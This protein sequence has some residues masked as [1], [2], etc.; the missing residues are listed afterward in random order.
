MHKVIGGTLIASLAMFAGVAT[1]QDASI[2]VEPVT[3]TMFQR[4]GEEIRVYSAKLICGNPGIIKRPVPFADGLGGGPALVPGEYL[5]AVNIHNPDPDNAVTFTKKVAEA[6]PERLLPEVGEVSDRVTETLG[7]DQALEVDCTDAFLLLGRDGGEEEMVAPDEVRPSS[8]LKG[9]VV[10][11][12]R[13]RPN[14]SPPLD[15]VGVYTVAGPRDGRL[16]PG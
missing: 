7:P 8:F 13:G 11:E 2:D 15:V 4:Q 1:A 14:Q 6:L 9:F 16:P 3:P 5:T 12:T 10:I